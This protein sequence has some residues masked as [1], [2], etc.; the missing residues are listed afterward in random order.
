MYV[1]FTPSDG[2]IKGVVGVSGE[3]G[4]GESIGRLARGSGLENSWSSFLV[5]SRI[6]SI[7]GVVGSAGWLLLGGASESLEIVF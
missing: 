3:I 2:L 4:I 7:G 6:G 1:M 5:S